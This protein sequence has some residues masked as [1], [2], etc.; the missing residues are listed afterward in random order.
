MLQFLF[1][2]Y[3]AYPDIMSLRLYIYIY[4]Y[5]YAYSKT[6][7]NTHTHTCIFEII[8]IYVWAEKFIWCYICCWGHFWPMGFK[9]CCTDGRCIER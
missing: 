3:F 1:H 8:D 9:Q 5:I 2:A 6:D 7:A 4:I